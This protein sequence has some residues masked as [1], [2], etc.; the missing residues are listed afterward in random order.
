MDE[1]QKNKMQKDQPTIQVSDDGPLLVRGPVEVI[2]MEG[3][4]FDRDTKNLALCR[5]GASSDKPFCDGSHEKIGFDSEVR[6]KG[7]KVIELP[8]RE[9]RAG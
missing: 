4:A 2:D 7:P 9:R 1:R 5:C 3:H 6:A 8:E